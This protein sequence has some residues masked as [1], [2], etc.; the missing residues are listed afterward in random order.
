MKS[1]TALA[2]V[3]SLLLALAQQ[4]AAK[5]PDLDTI[6]F[7]NLFHNGGAQLIPTTTG[8]IV[9]QAKL[10][11]ALL[12]EIPVP[13]GANQFVLKIP[14][15][16][17]INPRVPSTARPGERVRVY[18]RNTSLNV[19]YEVNQSKANGLSL[20]TA[21]RGEITA[22]DLAVNED[23][24]GQTPE[25]SLFAAWATNNSLPGPAS[26]TAPQDKD[27]DGFSNF[28]E[29]LAGTDPNS[30]TSIFRIMEVTRTSGT[31]LIKFGPISPGRLYTIYSSPTLGTS[32]WSS[33]GQVTPGVTGNFFI[34]GHP[35][36]VSN[37]M[38][39]KLNVSLTP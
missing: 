24:G 30:G 19:T 31:N 27:G 15:D 3:G 37:K 23:I 33:I 22:L 34:F 14:M 2:I 6:Y 21:D 26:A 29:F 5:R 10:N 8:Q 39:Y 25:M 16:D 13:A 36:P 38:F 4:A 35:T 28:D 20:P 11:G 32:S 18:L 9:V 17:G 1:S 12:C 7:G